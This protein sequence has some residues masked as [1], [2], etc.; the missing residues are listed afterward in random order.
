M[1]TWPDHLTAEELFTAISEPKRAQ[2]YGSYYGMFLSQLNE[3]EFDIEDLP[4][5]LEWVSNQPHRRALDDS[6]DGVFI[7]NILHQGWQHLHAPNV[8]P[9]FAKAAVS[10]LEER[11][12]IVDNQYV[13]NLTSATFREVLAGDTEK[14]RDLM[15]AM[16]PLAIDLR[17]RTVFAFSDTPVVLTED[18]PW[19]IEQLNQ[20]HD[21]EVKRLIAEL[22]HRVFDKYDPYQQT[23]VYNACHTFPILGEEMRMMI[24]AWDLESSEIQEIKNRYYE[25]VARRE[26]YQN[27]PRLEPP[28]AVRIA[29][30]LERFE[31]G[32]TYAWFWLTQDM[33]LEADD[34]H[35]KG[36]FEPDLLE[37]PGWQA[38]N[39]PTRQ[40]IVRAAHE[41]ILN[42]D[43]NTEDWLGTSSIS[44]S[45]IGGYRAFFLL[46]QVENDTLLN[47]P[48]EVWQKWSPTLLA[49]PYGTGTEESRRHYKMVDLGYQFASQE[50]IDALMVLID[51]ENEKDGYVFSVTKVE[52]CYDRQLESA[53]LKKVKDST[54]APK[55]MGVLLSTLLKNE[56]LDA[57]E[58]AQSFL[59]VPLL[60]EGVDRERAI[61]AAHVLSAYATMEG[62]PLVWAAMQ[63][64]TEFG[65]EVV[66]VLRNQGSYGKSV[67]LQELSESEV[68]DLYIWLVEQYPYNEDVRAEG[69]RWTT[70]QESASQ[71]KGQVLQHLEYRGSFEACRQIQRVMQRFPELNWLKRTLEHAYEVARQQTWTPTSP[72][73]IL[74][75]LSNPERRLIRSGDELVA[76]IL[77]SLQ[78]LESTLRDELLAV[79]D[80]WNMDESRN[81][82]YWPKDEEHF[83]GYVARHLIHDLK[84]RGLVVH[85]EVEIRRGSGSGSSRAPG[86]EVDIYVSAVSEQD[87]VLRAVIEVKGCWNDGLLTSMQT[88]LT[89]RYLREN[90]CSNGIYLVGWFNCEQWRTENRKTAALRKAPYLEALKQTLNV[91]ANDLSRDGV[92][93]KALV[94]DTSLR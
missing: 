36:Q 79:D 72:D 20:G 1:A 58:F 40:R 3:W 38:A 69:V 35:Y 92:N 34:T 44:Y 87:D 73:D 49:F 56:C 7:D 47:V 57:L 65:K 12:V 94:L 66:A 2:F 37:T 6:I 62:W 83:S 78:R 32:E 68:A 25:S 52:G 22:I 18:V 24:S 28:P 84:E 86:E 61:V 11:D 85:R 51:Q 93:I 75:L 48:V 41:Y 21:E 77:E 64:D 82:E 30:H 55:A 54:L 60:T 80:L 53:L 8:L 59:T 5:A 9:A 23:L 63:N 17:Y 67:D 88:Q 91:Q 19:L 33:Q 70:P 81:K 29:N 42:A 74:S 16:L 27:R 15:L 43:P 90:S 31:S 10:R 45:A 76:A 71:W 14:R 46:K 39:D 26:R 50:I 89:E 4:V 13:E